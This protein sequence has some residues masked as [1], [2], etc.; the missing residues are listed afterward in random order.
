M[1]LLRK[2]RRLVIIAL[3]VLA[4]LLVLFGARNLHA[5][6]PA[7]NSGPLPSAAH[8]VDHFQLVMVVDPGHRPLGTGDYLAVP[9]HRN[10]VAL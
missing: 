3:A 7:Q 9:L 2:Y 8:K 10:A 4:M 1:P 5:Q 6:S